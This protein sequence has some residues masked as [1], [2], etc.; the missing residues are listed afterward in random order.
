MSDSILLEPAFILAV[1]VI[2]TALVLSVAFCINRLRTPMMCER[3]GTEQRLYPADR[4]FARGNTW[5]CVKCWAVL[6]SKGKVVNELPAPAPWR[7]LPGM[8]GPV[9]DAA[10]AATSREADDRIHA[11]SNATTM[12]SVTELLEVLDS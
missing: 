11:S 3:C 1:G 8:A 6:D 2:P 7:V 12:R 5:S 9:Q 10:E 4:R